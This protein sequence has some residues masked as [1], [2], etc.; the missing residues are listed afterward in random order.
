[1]WSSYVKKTV[2]VNGFAEAIDMLTGQRAM[3]FSVTNP[4]QNYTSVKIE[5]AI[6][7]ELEA[8]VEVIAEENKDQQIIQKWSNNYPE[9]LQTVIQK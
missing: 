1:M 5:I 4:T 9:M 8:E 3:L 6:E 7:E 2:S